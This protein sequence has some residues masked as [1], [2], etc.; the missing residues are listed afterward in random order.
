VTAV[1]AAVRLP[2]VLRLARL[3]NASDVHLSVGRPP[4]FRIDGTLQDMSGSAV[5]AA[6]L[7]ALTLT[8]LNDLARRSLEESGDV[9]VT[10]L[11]P[12]LGP[13]RVHVYRAG[14]GVQFA[15]RLLAQELPLLEDLELPASVASFVERNSGLVLITGPTGSGKSTALAALV[16]RINRTT[17]RHIITVEDPIEY[18]HV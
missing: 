16:D 12:E 13:F 11:Y 17:A 4:A 14:A 10:Q 5:T 1:L 9:T 3:R 8:L 2:E 15:I 7:D 6:E 18:V